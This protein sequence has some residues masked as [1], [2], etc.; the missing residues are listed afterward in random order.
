MREMLIIRASAAQP[1]APAQWCVQADHLTNTQGLREVASGSLGDAL[2]AADGRA[3][4]LIIPGEQCLLCSI[5]LPIRSHSKLLKALPYALEERLAEDPD[6]LHFALGPRTASGAIGVAVI[7]IE[8]MQAWVDVLGGDKV[9]AVAIVPDTLCL[10]R[11]AAEG[12]SVLLDAPGHVVLRNGDTAGFAGEVDLLADSLLLQPD[13]DLQVYRHSE[14]AL[15]EVLGARAVRDVAQ[16]LDALR[17]Q[18]GSPRINLLQGSYAPRSNLGK[19]FAVLRLTS[20]L[21]AA[22]LL[23]ALASAGIR[24]VSL[25]QQLQQLQ[26]QQQ[27]LM[28]SAFPQI[29]RIVNAKVQAQQALQ[30][31]R[32]GSGGGSLYALTSALTDALRQVPGLQL[33]SL[34]LREGRIS[35]E[36]TGSNLQTLDGLRKVFADNR[37][38]ALNVDSANASDGKV[39]IRATLEHRS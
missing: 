13:A 26:T 4:S 32:G 14:V 7:A 28:H 17:G 39:S 12:M 21:A 8:Q 6:N 18:A 9:N 3:V 27:E 16:P 23:L 19:R 24:H 25:Q 33:Q 35:L 38:Y 11:P 5:D 30:A 22:C 20:M 1:E 34:Q 37:Q 36:M 10:P 15:P 31:L 29:H 2:A